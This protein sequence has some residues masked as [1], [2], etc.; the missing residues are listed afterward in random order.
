MA[1]SYII[2]EYKKEL[3]EVK[4][5]AFNKLA[6]QAFQLQ[7]SENKVLKQFCST[8]NHRLTETA[9]LEHFPFLPISFFKTHPVITGIEMP[10]L[11]FES[12]GTTGQDRSRH[13]VTDP[14]LY[15]QSLTTGFQNVFGPTN[16]WQILALLPGYLEQPYASLVYMVRQLMKQSKTGEEN[17]YLHQYEALFH[18]LERA[19]SK[20][21][22][23]LLVGVTYALLDFAEKFPV[24]LKHTHILETGGMKGRRKEML[25][26]EVHSIL[27]HHFGIENIYSEYGMTELLSQAYSLK[28]GVFSCPP[29]MKVLVRDEDDPFLVK[30]S[31]RGALN[32]IDLANIHSCCFIATEDVGEVYEDG[33]FRV[34]GRMDASELRGCSL[35]AV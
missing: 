21:I 6:Q 23:T 13:Y 1:E 19:E 10:P 34:L 32:M 16:D 14:G 2:S 12:S 28:D 29:W 20:G 11:F 35:M 27:K 33:T 31:G 7:L 9:D 24:K 15:D 17:F 26:E 3:W 25:R 4:A 30:T 8:V 22:K 18:H 5:S